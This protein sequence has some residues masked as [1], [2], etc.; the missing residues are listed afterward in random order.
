MTDDFGNLIEP[1]TAA[2]IN[3]RLDAGD[4]RMSRIEAELESNS[5]TTRQVAES[6]RD[7]VAF[8]Q[9]AQGAF[10]VLNWIGAA[11]KPVGYIAA[12]ITAGLGLWAALKGHLR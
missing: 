2:T 1:A 5:A 10:K 6:T 8:F 7:L 9:A 12:A 3:A 4:V 11:A